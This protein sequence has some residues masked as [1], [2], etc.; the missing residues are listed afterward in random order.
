MGRA[1]QPGS[2]AAW[3]GARWLISRRVDVLTKC[4]YYHDSLIGV[5]FAW[6][7]N[8]TRH[9]WRLMIYLPSEALKNKQS[10][11]RTSVLIVSCFIVMASQYTSRTHTY[12]HI[13]I[14]TP[15]ICVLCYCILVYLLGT[16]H[17]LHSTCT[18]APSQLPGSLGSRADTRLV[19]WRGCFNC[20]N[21]SIR[22]V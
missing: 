15:T 11:R 8:R 21:W 20:C 22:F 4:A 2:P 13:Y 16:L 18:V 1:R 9:L 3:P 14:I 6:G 7:G 5:E 17:L 19:P 12:T 10:V